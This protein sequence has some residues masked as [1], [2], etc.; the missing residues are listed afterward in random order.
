MRLGFGCASLGSRISPR[1][2]LESLA[3][4]FDEGVRWFDLAPSYGDGQAEVIFSAFAR[5]RRDEIQICTKCGIASSRVG[6]ATSILRP[7]GRQVVRSVP[8]LRQMVSRGRATAEKVPLNANSI[9]RSLDRSLQRLCT[10]Y[11]NVFSLHDPDPSD[12]SR[13]DVLNALIRTRSSGKA[14]A[15]G[16][17][18]SLDVAI[19]AAGHPEVFDILQFENNPESRSIFQLH[20]KVGEQLSRFTLVTFSIFVAPRPQLRVPAGVMVELGYDMAPE[21]A[22][23]AAAIDWA[24]QS[25]DSSRVLVSMFQPCHLTFNVQRVKD[26]SRPSLESLEAFFAHLAPAQISANAVGKNA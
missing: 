18:G 1:A 15:I 14:K 12:L 13:D 16:V 20:A 23:R 19:E 11:V 3:L 9:E 25:N 21:A 8:K 26:T 5:S 4:A 17:A 22:L 2:G 24:L 10:D 7:L 6:W